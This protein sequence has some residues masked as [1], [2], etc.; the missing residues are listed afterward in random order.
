MTD[1]AQAR[2]LQMPAHGH[3]HSHGGGHGAVSSDRRGRMI[4]LAVLVPVLLGTVVG[5]I[6]LWPSPSSLPDRLPMMDPDAAVMSAQITGPADEDRMLAPAVLTGIPDESIERLQAGGHPIPEVGIDIRVNMP[7][8]QMR[9]GVSDGAKLRIIYLPYAVG[10]DDGSG[11]EASPY[12]FLDYDRTAP[13]GMLAIFYGLLVLAVAR[14][15]GLAAFIGLGLSV[16]VLGFF[17]LPALLAGQP[18]MLVA[19]VS[20]TAIMLVSLYVAHGVSVRTSTALLGTVC[21]LALTTAIAWW[22]T[23]A[24]QLTGLTSEE[25]LMLPVYVPNLD[26]RGLVMC[27][28][29][30][31]GL[32]VLNDVTVTQASAVWEMRALAPQAGRWALFRGALRIGRDHI[33]STVYTIVFAYLGASLPLFMLVIMQQQAVGVSLTSGAIAE[34]VVR[35]LVSS[36]G[37]VLAIPITT[38]IAAAMAP[39]AVLNLPEADQPVVADGSPDDDSDD[40]AAR[41]DSEISELR[42]VEL[43]GRQGDHDSGSSGS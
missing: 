35:T 16:A 19:L 15:R 27:G 13:I 5:L 7:T 21:G 36:I 20:S 42:E 30:L 22:A 2:K 10:V 32:G 3:G 33:A 28:I 40:V 37:L 9:V 24:S 1:P 41:D 43:T 18:P 23:G 4:I 12:V 29:V 8:E 6:G 11:N 25:A 39:D 17:T 14:W 26:M 34:E 31:A 38:A